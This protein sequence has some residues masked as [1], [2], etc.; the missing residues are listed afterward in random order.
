MVRS[1]LLFSSLV[2]STFLVGCTP[3]APQNSLNTLEATGIIGGE[4]VAAVDKLPN[5]IVAVY[6]SV[7]GQLCTGTLINKNVVLTAAHC[8]G[9]EINKMYVFFGKNLQVDGVYVR[10]DK[11]EI[12][13][14]WNASTDKDMGDLALLHFQGPLPASFKPATMLPTNMADVLQ[15][16]TNVVVAGYGVTDAEIQQAPSALRKTKVTI[17]D[18]KFADSEITIDQSN[19]KGVCHG[20]SGGPAFIDIDG[21][22]Y[23]WGITSRGV[24]DTS[25]T[26]K[27]TAALTSIPYYRSWINRMNAKLSSSLIN[28]IWRS[29]A[30]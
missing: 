23:L 25:R 30:Q 9:Q 17:A 18:A 5:S 1:Q 21:T 2:A 10:I 16:G 11:A 24:N 14:Y 15:N 28:F 7:E 12:S 26:C 4:E 3:S 22:Y 13:P 19:G 20:D 29:Q 6:D 8:V 27:T